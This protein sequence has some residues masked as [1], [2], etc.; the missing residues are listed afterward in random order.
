V[1]DRLYGALEY[2]SLALQ[3]AP[4]PDNLLN[5]G[6]FQV[7]PYTSMGFVIDNKIVSSINFVRLIADIE[8]REQSNFN[9]NQR[10]L[11]RRGHQAYDFNNYHGHTFEIT[12][13][14]REQLKRSVGNLIDNAYNE[15]LTGSIR[16]LQDR[17]LYNARMHFGKSYTK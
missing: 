14:L 11:K 17:F 12:G 1:L 4:V 3:V 8:Q 9:V 7:S 10:Q 5:Q 6:L 15:R 2:I 16:Q 13:M